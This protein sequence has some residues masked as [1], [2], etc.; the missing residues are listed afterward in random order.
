MSL[1]TR[2]LQL[3]QSAQ[4][5]LRNNLWNEKFVDAILIA[6]NTELSIKLRYRGGH[7]RDYPKKSYEIRVGN[8][9]LHYNAEFDDP[10]MMRNALSFQFFKKIGVVSPRTRH[11]NLLINGVSQGVYLEI[12]G[13]DRSF[14]TKRNVP[15][16]SLLYAINN[17][18]NFRLTGEDKMKKKSLSA[19]YE[20]VIG[21]SKELIR[22]ADFVKKIRTLRG[23]QLKVY[24]KGHLDIPQ[25]LR[26]LAGAVC[27]GNYDG[28]DQNYALY[29]TSKSLKYRISPW[30]YEGSWGRNCYG[31][32]NNY[33][34]LRITGYN[35]LTAVLL[36]FPDIR[37]LYRNILQNI[38]DKEFN[39]RI[40]MPEINEMHSR[41]YPYLLSDRTRKHSPLSVRSDLNV[42]YKY[43]EQRREFLIKEIDTL[44]DRKLSL[45]K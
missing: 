1:P 43:I 19:G 33:K 15:M 36:S 31:E 12:E 27:T 16:R 25:Y 29:R 44:N 24:L 37:I 6:D 28:F 38:L 34:A 4:T 8:R 32:I 13:V 30:D 21:S 22:I 5:E 3:Q 11:V 2:H 35:G 45:P 20:V 41:L 39:I 26:W 23:N 40:L 14:F 9:R 18:A 7:T 42:Y 17:N 10:T